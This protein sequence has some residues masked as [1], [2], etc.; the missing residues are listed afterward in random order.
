MPKASKPGAASEAQQIASTH[1]LI[2]LV[3]ARDRE[4]LRSEEQ[5]I[6]ET[7]DG[8]GDGLMITLR[9]VSSSGSDET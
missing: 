1:P 4:G 7:T 8:Y 6:D 3:K 9:E 2:F 5:R